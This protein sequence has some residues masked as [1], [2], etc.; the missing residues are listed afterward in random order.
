MERPR[1]QCFRAGRT[2]CKAMWPER[3]PHRGGVGCLR[4]FDARSRWSQGLHSRR[5]RTTIRRWSRQPGLPHES[6]DRHVEI[7]QA[8]GRSRVAVC[9]AGLG[10]AGGRATGG[11]PEPAD[12]DHR[13]PAGR[14]RRRYRHPHHFREAAAPPRPAHRDREQGRPVRQHRRRSGVQCRSRRLHP[15]RFAARA[16]H[17]EP[18]TLPE[19]V[20]R[21]RRSSRRSRS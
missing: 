9:G 21:S 6:R 19:H 3:K 7:A 1:Q 17:D 16:D 13:V 10:R 5:P 12:Q 20:V 14:R 11:L 8:D 18:A 15:A 4:R 2:L